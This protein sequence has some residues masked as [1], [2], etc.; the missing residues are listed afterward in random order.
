[1][2]KFQAYVAEFRTEDESIVR[3]AL[4]RCSFPFVP[5]STVVWAVGSSRVATSCSVRLAGLGRAVVRLL[6]AAMLH[7]RRVITLRLTPG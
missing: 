2:D 7:R 5:P 3:L 6:C 4:G 1:M